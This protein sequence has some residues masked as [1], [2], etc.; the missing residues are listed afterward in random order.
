MHSKNLRLFIFPVELRPWTPEQKEFM[1]VLLENILTSS[2]TFSGSLVLWFSGSQ[3]LWFSGSQHFWFF[4]SLV[5]WFL[6]P[7]KIAVK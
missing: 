2:N 5:L 3:I 6:L 7:E 4:G 1:G